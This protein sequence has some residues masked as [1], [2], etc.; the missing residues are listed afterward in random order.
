MAQFGG[1]RYVSSVGEYSS[2]AQ[3]GVT[4]RYGA[5][6]QPPLSQTPITYST[7]RYGAA[8]LIESEKAESRVGRDEIEKVE[9]DKVESNSGLGMLKPY[10]CEF[11]GT[12]MLVFTV[13]I[14]TS[15]DKA[16]SQQWQ[17]TA[18]G[19]ALT[20]IIYSVAFVSGGN[21]NPAVSL[22]LLLARKIS[23]CK[24]ICYVIIQ[25][26]AGLLAGLLFGVVFLKRPSAISPSEPF[27][28]TQ[29]AIVEFVFTTMLCFVVLN[30]AASTRNNPKNDGN[31]FFALAIGFVII[32]AGYAGG[33]I[34][35]AALNPAIALGLDLP[36]H[37]VVIG[38]LYALME[39]LGGVFAALLFRLCR[40]EDYRSFEGADDVQSYVPSL[41]ARLFGEFIG[42]FFIVLTFGL[43][44]IM[45]TGATAWSVGAALLCMTYALGN[46]SGG[47]FNPAVTVAVLLSGQSTRVS[48]DVGSYMLVQ[49]FGGIMAALLI[50][51]MHHHAPTKNMAFNIAGLDDEFHWTT[52]LAVETIFTFFLAYVVLAVSSFADGS[53]RNFYF[54]LAI[55]FSM[56]A[57]VFAAGPISGGYMNPAAALSLAITGLPRFQSHVVVHDT[58]GWG[59]YVVDYVLMGLSLA[60]QFIA[61]F[62]PWLMYFVCEVI[63]AALAA[64]VF[65]CTHPGKDGKIPED[66]A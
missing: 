26:I 12:F 32:A 57:G 14:L 53:R 50:N 3:S 65:K 23:V 11:V 41:G 52:V 24:C 30:V 48:K 58:L 25:C 21:V 10:L 40:E 62:L 13:A 61:Y 36:Y 8:Q 45:L 1:P 17:P 51:Y 59:Q 27:H 39:V 44:V 29:A 42:T 9:S 6:V 22:S 35:G 56:T 49:L 28:F 15:I 38:L 55:G 4:T 37:N 19:C 54:A 66:L 33:N 5:I 46:V 60:S 2:I 31:Q 7:T 64:G 16:E 47:H 18:I 20:V 34:S 63:G 43:N